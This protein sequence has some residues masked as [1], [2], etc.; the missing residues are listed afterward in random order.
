MLECGCDPPTDEIPAG[1]VEIIG[2][3]EPY[4]VTVDSAVRPGSTLPD[5]A[6]PLAAFL[7]ANKV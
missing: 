5:G 2:A 3:S 7:V 6:V 4:G 1:L